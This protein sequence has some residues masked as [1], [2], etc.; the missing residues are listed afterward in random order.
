LI[1]TLNRP[2]LTERELETL[3]LIAAGRSNKEIGAQLH[4]TEGTVKTHVKSILKK[5]NTPG[6]TAA[7]R[8]A[9]HRGLVHMS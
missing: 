5:L 3:H 6:R 4:I 1:E 2:G 9:V 8:E 7:V